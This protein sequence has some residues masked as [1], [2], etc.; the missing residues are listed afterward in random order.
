ME[1]RLNI[2]EFDKRKSPVVQVASRI[3]EAFNIFKGADLLIVNRKI[4]GDFFEIMADSL[5]E[6]RKGVV[7]LERFYK[8]DKCN[9]KGMQVE[10][11][12][13]ENKNLVK[14]FTEFSS[15]IPEV[16]T[17]SEEDREFYT[18]KVNEYTSKIRDIKPEKTILKT[19]QYKKFDL[20][21]FDLLEDSVLESMSN[22]YAGL[23]L[24]FLTAM[25]WASLED[26]SIALTTVEQKDYV[27]LVLV[28]V[29]INDEK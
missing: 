23:G 25:S 10:G 11:L 27:D 16:A 20:A 18:N 12:S 2:I 5:Y 7:L 21:E 24:N 1:S 26:V 15:S 17:L 6:Y 29:K 14:E 19:Y 28:P 9:P 8:K 4:K 3:R 13:E 22:L